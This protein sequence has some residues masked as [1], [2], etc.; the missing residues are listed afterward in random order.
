MV[1]DNGIVW[2]QKDYYEYQKNAAAMTTMNRSIGPIA[3]FDSGMEGIS[4]LKEIYRLM[5]Y[6]NYIFYGNSANAVEVKECLCLRTVI[7][8]GNILGL[9]ENCL[10]SDGPRQRML[11]AEHFEE[12]NI[13]TPNEQYSQPLYLR[14]QRLT[15]SGR[16]KS[17]ICPE[18]RI[19]ISEYSLRE[20]SLFALSPQKHKTAQ[21]INNLTDIQLIDICQNE[22]Q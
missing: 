4:V 19:F 15:E 17:H 20:F 5:P 16:K 18:A 6:E 12:K 21:I 8:Q 7:R 13:C 9:A 11:K 22:K 10:N 3:V 1:T 2:Q 14:F